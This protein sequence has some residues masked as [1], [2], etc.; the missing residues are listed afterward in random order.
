MPKEIKELV[1]QL[2]HDF[3]EITKTW[4]ERHEAESKLGVERSELIAKNAEMATDFM[5]QIKDIEIAVATNR[6]TGEVETSE[7]KNLDTLN[8][9]LKAY[10]KG[11]V[12]ADEFAETKAA[13]NHF[14]AHGKDSL[15]DAQRKSLNTVI[16]PQ[17]GY[18]MMPQWGSKDNAKKFDEFGAITLVDRINSNKGTYKDIIDWGDYEESYYQKELEEN[19]STQDGEDFKLFEVTVHAQKYGKKFSREFLEDD[20]D[21]VQ[22]KVMQRLQMGMERKRAL[23]LITGIDPKKPRG[24]MSYANGTTYGT[25]EQVDSVNV[26]S[27]SWDDVFD[28]VRTSLKDGYKNNASYLMSDST[29]AELLISKDDDGRY[30]VGNQI[31]FFSG[32]RFSISIL[33][34]KVTFD[35]NVAEVAG[36]SLSIAYG[37]FEEAYK[38]IERSGNS[39]VRNET[40]P[41][42]VKLWLRNRH[43][44]AVMNFDA[45]KILKIKNA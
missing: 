35:A 7:A 34:N 26:G 31:N 43:N 29:F 4:D 42:Y 22:N 20:A 44:G 1:G 12:E 10:G 24:I 33:G 23:A 19:D 9:T 3:A 40:H 5:K 36:N 25:V 13:F 21:G 16:D 27:V 39:I 11:K 32:D 8:H 38:L 37:D 41:D 18:F 45:Y 14:M 28:G 30:Q 6:Q 2:T 15:S 17:G